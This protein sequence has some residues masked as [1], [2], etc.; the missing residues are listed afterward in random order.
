MV[1]VVYNQEANIYFLWIKKL[2]HHVLEKNINLQK[3]KKLST[4]IV[5]KI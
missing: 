3:K 2:C 4:K 1:T 5:H